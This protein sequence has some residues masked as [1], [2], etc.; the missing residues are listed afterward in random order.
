MTRIWG[1]TEVE[2]YADKAAHRDDGDEDE[3]KSDTRYD[4]L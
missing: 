1:Y 2:E 3:N 4:D